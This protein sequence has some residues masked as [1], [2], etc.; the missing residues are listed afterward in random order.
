MREPEIAQIIS[1]LENGGK[2]GSH[3]VR[4]LGREKT[5]LF[6]VK[7]IFFAK[8]SFSS[9]RILIAGSK[10][11]SAEEL[12]IKYVSNQSC[13]QP[14][15]QFSSQPANRSIQARGGPRPL[16]PQRS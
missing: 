7:L 8:A 15:R 11:M 3:I 6:R 5:L 1:V 2:N 9:L 16:P 12:I 10:G 14:M 13:S 4:Q